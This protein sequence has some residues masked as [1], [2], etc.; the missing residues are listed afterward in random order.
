MQSP[1]GQPSRWPSLT[2]C[3]VRPSSEQH[4]PTEDLEGFQVSQQHDLVLCKL[5]M[6]PVAKNFRF[7][8]LKTKE[9]I[10][11]TH[12]WFFYEEATLS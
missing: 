2:I 5:P 10:L 8:F 7:L 9:P 12:S 1:R 11:R 3:R 4:Q 6:M